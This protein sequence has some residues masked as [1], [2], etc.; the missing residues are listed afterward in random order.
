MTT[1]EYLQAKRFLPP[2]S[3]HIW[4]VADLRSK[5]APKTFEAS[6]FKAGNWGVIKK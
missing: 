3:L 2:V 4:G 6:T 1:P 5:K